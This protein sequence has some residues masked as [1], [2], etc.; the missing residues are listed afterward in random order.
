METELLKIRCIRFRHQSLPLNFISKMEF[1]RW[2]KKHYAMCG[3]PEKVYSY[4]ST[5]FYIYWREMTKT[6]NVGKMC[7][8]MYSHTDPIHG[9]VYYFGSIEKYNVM[10]IILEKI[11]R[12]KKET[13]IIPCT[14]NNFM[15]KM[16][17]ENLRNFRNC[18]SEKNIIIALFNNFLTDKNF[19]FNQV[20]TILSKM[21]INK[22]AIYSVIGNIVMH[23]ERDSREI[24]LKDLIAK[25]DEL[26]T[27]LN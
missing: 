21:G 16:T 3:S 12:E 18:W 22:N 13:Y 25:L 14:L 27:Y 15:M 5:K 2:F 17:D 9:L 10:N 26:K 19:N 7:L 11:L 20:N 4:F 1:Y 23:Q 8:S 6:L 24:L